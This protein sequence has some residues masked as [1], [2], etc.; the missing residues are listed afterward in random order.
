M[1]QGTRFFF[2]FHSLKFMNSVAVT[3]R[4]GAGRGA[5]PP[6]EAAMGERGRTARAPGAPRGCGAG[7]WLRR[8]LGF[9]CLPPLCSV[10]ALLPLAA[11]WVASRGSIHHSPASRSLLVGSPSVCPGV[12]RQQQTVKRKKIGWKYQCTLVTINPAF[13]LC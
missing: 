4:A 1:I 7:K 11:T 2:F 12:T 3:V 6:A 10:F 8:D 5:S 13:N 9:L